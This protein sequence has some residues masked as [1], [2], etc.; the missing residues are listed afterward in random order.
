M[1]LVPE[2]S[3]NGMGSHTHCHTSG[4]RHIGNTWHG[5]VHSCGDLVSAKIFAYVDHMGKPFPTSHLCGYVHR[6]RERERESDSMCGRGVCMQSEYKHRERAG[7][8]MECMYSEARGNACI[9]ERDDILV[10]N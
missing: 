3:H 4:Q 7:I 10:Y 1:H 8:A 2:F 5:G 9:S 6:Q